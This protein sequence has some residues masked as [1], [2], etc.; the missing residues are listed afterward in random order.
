MVA[1]GFALFL[2]IGLMAFWL[3]A[4]VLGF[5]VPMWLTIGTMHMLRPKRLTDSEEDEN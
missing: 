2:L 1:L 5:A 4:F 3:L